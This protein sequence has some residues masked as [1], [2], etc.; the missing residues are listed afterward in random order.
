MSQLSS[1]AQQTHLSQLPLLLLLRLFGLERIL[2]ATLCLRA[3][4]LVGCWERRRWGL[5]AFDWIAAQL[6][7]TDALSRPVISSFLL[8]RRKRVDES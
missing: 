1:P 8:P 6:N 7:L 4:R 3:S 2:E 5:L